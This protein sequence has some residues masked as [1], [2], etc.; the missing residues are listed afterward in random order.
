[1][2]VIVSVSASETVRFHFPYSPYGGMETPDFRL[3]VS[4]VSKRFLAME[5]VWIVA[6]A[7]GF[8]GH[9]L[10]DFLPS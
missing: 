7:M 4:S 1:L 2:V 6:S 3:G 10:V 8:G 5:T 9:F